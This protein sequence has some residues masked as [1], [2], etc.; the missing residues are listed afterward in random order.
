MARSGI[1]SGEIA[2]GMIHVADSEKSGECRC[3]STHA[4]HDIDRQAAHDWIKEAAD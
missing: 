2:N 1:D 3:R 4:M